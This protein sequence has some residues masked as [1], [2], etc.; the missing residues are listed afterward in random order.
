MAH[1]ESVVICTAVGTNVTAVPAFAGEAGGGL[2]SDYSPWSCYGSDVWGLLS[3]SW[4]GGTQSNT[5]LF[6]VCAYMPCMLQ[7]RM[8]PDLCTAGCLSLASLVHSAANYFLQFVLIIKCICIWKSIFLAASNS[9][10]TIQIPEW[11]QFLNKENMVAK[12]IFS[13]PV[14]LY[15]EMEITTNKSSSDSWLLR[16][17]DR[18]TSIPVHRYH[19]KQLC[20]TES[21][22]KLS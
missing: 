6:R 22:S 14:S 10:L 4:A 21:W 17:L 1:T 12:R 15:S 16:W 18:Q 9:A 19:F 2:H 5:C 3:V 7:S 8:D 11:M 13:L 20:H